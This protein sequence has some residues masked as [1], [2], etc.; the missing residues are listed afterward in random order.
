MTSEGAEAE[1]RAKAASQPDC[2]PLV[3][4]RQAGTKAHAPIPCLVTR[5]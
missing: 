5:V 2:Q 3:V 1:A 4:F